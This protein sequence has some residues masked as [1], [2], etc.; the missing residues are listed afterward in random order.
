MSITLES[1]CALEKNNSALPFKSEERESLICI[2]IYPNILHVLFLYLDVERAVPASRAATLLLISSWLA[3]EFKICS[4]KARVSSDTKNI[5]ILVSFVDR[6]QTLQ[7]KDKGKLDAKPTMKSWKMPK[8][9]IIGFENNVEPIRQPFLLC[10]RVRPH[11]FM[12][13]IL[14][15]KSDEFFQNFINF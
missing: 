7:K 8:K 3:Q 2:L 10:W 15:F 12:I 14:D 11:S 4:I 13:H 9:L 1:N 6:T 5:K